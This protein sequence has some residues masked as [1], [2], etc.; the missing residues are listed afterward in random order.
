MHITHLIILVGTCITAINL[1]GETII[2]CFHQSLYFGNTM[3]T[4][5]IPLSQLWYHG[6]T[7]DVVSKQYSNGKSLFGIH[8]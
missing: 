6:F 2:G 5:L 3:E 7:D 1:N 8:H 4:L